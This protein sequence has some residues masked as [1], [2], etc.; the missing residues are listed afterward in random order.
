MA[1]HT[2]SQGALVFQAVESKRL[3]VILNDCLYP[4][5]KGK[6]L[7]DH[8]FS[9]Q[10]LSPIIFHKSLSP[11]TTFLLKVASRWEKKMKLQIPM[12]RKSQNQSFALGWTLVGWYIWF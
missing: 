1:T 11:D 10:I 12:N 8:I 6:M 3:T 4:V 7:M 2:C 9:I 5:C